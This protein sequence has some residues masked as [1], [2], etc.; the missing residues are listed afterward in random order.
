[1]F[2]LKNQTPGS[3]AVCGFSII[4]ILQEV[5]G[6]RHFVEQIIN[7]NK[8]GTESKMENPAYLERWTLC[9]SSSKNRKLTVK[10][11]WAGAR[12]R[13]KRAFL[14]HLSCLKG[15]FFKICVLSECIVH[16]LH[17]QN[18]HTFAYQKALLY[19]LLLFVSKIVE[20]LQCILNSFICYTVF[21]CPLKTPGVEK[22][23]RRNGL[24]AKSI[25]NVLLVFFIKAMQYES[26]T[27][28]VAETIQK[29]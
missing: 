14:Y 25:S 9:F 20:Y 26:E 29:K 18:T 3:K 4:L 21:L 13:K 1:M 12:K 7:F 27:I 10:L 2:Q 19:T 24:S 15:I 23:I 22:Y 16:S 5:K 11:W 17:F 8:N 6:P 28:I